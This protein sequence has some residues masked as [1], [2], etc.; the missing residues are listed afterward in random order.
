MPQE[1]TV[2]LPSS[3][4][5]S[6]RALIISALSGDNVCRKIKNLAKCDDT[7]VLV[8][9]LRMENAHFDIGAAGTAMRFLTAYLCIHEGEWTITGSERMRQRPIHILVEALRELGAEIDY[10]GNDGFPPLRIKGRQMQGGEITI[11]GSVS[12]Q[13]ISALLMI[14]P[15][16][17]NG[18]VLHLKGNVTSQPYIRMT[19]EIM[20]VYGVKSR[21]DECENTIRIGRQNYRTVDFTVEADWSASSYWYEMVA[22]SGVKVFMPNLYEKSLQGDS[23]I[24][25][26]FKPMGVETTFTGDGVEIHKVG[27]GSEA[28]SYSCV[29]TPDL[30]Q[31]IVATCCALDKRFDIKGL[32]TLKIKE[33]DRIAAL[34]KEC[35]KLGY[36]LEES[37]DDGL[38]YAGR[39]EERKKDILISTYKDHRMA[40]SFAPLAIKLGTIRIED[41]MV[42]T[43]SYP[44]FWS[45]TNEM[46]QI[47][48]E[49]GSN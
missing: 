18:L 48:E 20:S 6:N 44:T 1:Q 40:M 16:M 32:H 41:P 46:L 13:Y 30:A 25:D 47:E 43:K 15:C 9:A 35:G 28:V 7:D 26:L 23:A 17:D 29:D 4:S 34:I 37:E 38:S 21:W 14:A 27:E 45:D 24:A 3:K 36:C 11:D 22:M 19:L 31:T 2:Y 49:K 5:I 10:L 12:S 42:V 39:K 33:T 8:A